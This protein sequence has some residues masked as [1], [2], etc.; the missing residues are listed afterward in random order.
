MRRALKIRLQMGT[1]K[2]LVSCRD[3]VTY[4]ESKIHIFSH[5]TFVECITLSY[6]V[7]PYV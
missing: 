1:M 3:E 4:L 5:G 2:R 6:M 7:R